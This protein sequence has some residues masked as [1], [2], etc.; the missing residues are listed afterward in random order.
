MKDQTKEKLQAS[1]E[2]QE[3]VKEA[4]AAA[5]DTK[6]TTKESV[7]FPQ[8]AL[9]TSDSGEEPMYEAQ[10]VTT[11]EEFQNSVMTGEGWEKRL[12]WCK[13]AGIGCLVLAVLVLMMRD[14]LATVVFV[15]G[16]A[17]LMLY[18]PYKIKRD[19]QDRWNSDVYLHGLITKVEIYSDRIRYFTQYTSAVW[20]WHYIWGMIETDTNLY[21]MVTSTTRLNISK[22]SCSEEMIEFLRE[23]SARYGHYISQ[24]GEDVSID[25]EEPET[26]EA[27]GEAA[28]EFIDNEE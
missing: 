6:A 5:E 15:A 11:F 7:V 10:V 22:A 20:P 17:A 3:A 27:A 1:E 4:A 18:L 21:I 19:I 9:M 25:D 16:A 28:A 26:E 13:Y 23:A 12:T 14:Y 24:T 8:T 2:A